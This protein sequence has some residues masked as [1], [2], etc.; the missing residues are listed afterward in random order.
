MSLSVFTIE[1]CATFIFVLVI[2]LSKGNPFLL[3][4]TVLLLVF[5]FQASF[6]P[7]ASLAIA[8]N[9]NYWHH[10]LVPLSAQFSGS[11][12]AVF[13]FRFARSVQV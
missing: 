3:A 7:A 5:F 12:L 1:F 11:L 13:L 8:L 10:V 2:L 6:N 4:F 9:S